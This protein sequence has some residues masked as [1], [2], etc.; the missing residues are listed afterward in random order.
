MA[1]RDHPDLWGILAARA[2]PA[3]VAGTVALQDP[4]VIIPAAAPAAPV[5]AMAP[6]A[7]PALRDPA[8]ALA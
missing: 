1:L 5:A 6:M 2:L 8:V 7:L 3:I 4:P